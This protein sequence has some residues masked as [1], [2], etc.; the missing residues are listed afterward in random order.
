LFLPGIK[1]NENSLAW[2]ELNTVLAKLLWKYDLELVN[3]DVDWQRDSTMHTLWKKPELMVR[4]KTRK[5][6]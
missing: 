5:D 6:E 1:A 2:I 4:V 3:Q